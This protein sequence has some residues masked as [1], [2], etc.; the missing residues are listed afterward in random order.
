MSCNWLPCCV[1]WSR[2][3][4][5][6]LFSPLHNFSFKSA[7][8]PLGK[9]QGSF[10]ALTAWPLPHLGRGHG[11]T[12][13]HQPQASQAAQT[14]GCSASS[15]SSSTSSWFCFDSDFTP[16]HRIKTYIETYCESSPMQ[17]FSTIKHSGRIHPWTSSPPPPNL[18]SG[19]RTAPC[20]LLGNYDT[21]S[22]ELPQT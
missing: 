20:S 14:Q 11:N 8:K 18:W 17:L 6:L 19:W 12:A 21:D 4:A 15:D 13:P 16:W 1:A 5:V 9:V 3:W 10:L 2:G 7:A 22:W